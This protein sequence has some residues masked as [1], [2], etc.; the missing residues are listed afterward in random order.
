MQEA[1]TQE[2]LYLEPVVLQTPTPQNE[3][4]NLVKNLKVDIKF[5]DFKILE[6]FTECKF[7][8]ETEP[9]ILN[10]GELYRFNDDNVFVNEL[11]N[12]KQSFRVEFFDI[13]KRPQK[14]LPE[15]SISINKKLTK[16][17]E[18][19]EIIKEK[20]IKIFEL[21][22]KK[23][24][25]KLE[26]FKIEGEKEM[27]IFR[28]NRKYIISSSLFFITILLIASY[29]FYK[30]SMGIEKATI[31]KI[32][33]IP[34]LFS[35]VLVSFISMIKY[36]IFIRDKEIILG[37]LKINM[38]KINSATV[39]ID[40]VKGNRYDRYLEIVTDDNRLIKIRLNISDELLFLKI[41]QNNIK[42]KFI[43]KKY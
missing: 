23:L 8:N 18:E 3:I 41:I 5:I 36:K 13:R 1:K 7:V 42:K 26:T 4:L 29:S 35:Y 37:K 15:I 31:L 12:I 39:K 2:N 11:E 22:L 21:F 27:Y 30:I 17:I 40:K 6:I 28:G 25:K 9:R 33:L 38:D 14:P 10:Q 43:I 16:I 32:I 19:Y 24:E 34:V 20:I